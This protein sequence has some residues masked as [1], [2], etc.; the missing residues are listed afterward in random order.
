[1]K[2]FKSFAFLVLACVFLP[3]AVWAAPYKVDKDHTSVSFKVRHLFSNVQGQFRDFDGTIEYDPDKPETWGAQGTIQVGSIDTGVA[4]R[5]K[6]LKSADFFETDKYPTITFKTTKVTD[7]TKESANVEG[8]LMMHGVEKPVRVD[9]EIHGV[10][11]DPW[12]N[13]RAGFTATTKLNRQDFG[14][15]WNEKLDSGGFLVG[16]DVMVTIEMEAI[17][18]K[19]K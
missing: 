18:Q 16:D 14:V 4:Q 15:K 2:R 11:Q 12:G 13:T 6:H 17:L 3:S 8:L 5:D 1:M 7:V 9:V 19:G 10:G